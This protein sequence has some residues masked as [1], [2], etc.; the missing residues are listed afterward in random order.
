[1]ELA[2]ADGR[3]LVAAQARCIQPRNHIP[4]L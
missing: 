4:D 2:G 1:M 3:D